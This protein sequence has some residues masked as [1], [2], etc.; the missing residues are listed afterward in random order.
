[1]SNSGEHQTICAAMYTRLFTLTYLH[2]QSEG[3]NLLQN[4]L[5]IAQRDQHW[6]GVLRN[7]HH[8]DDKTFRNGSQFLQ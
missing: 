3:G 5:K 6:R 2:R 4:R 7:C 1:V 8:L